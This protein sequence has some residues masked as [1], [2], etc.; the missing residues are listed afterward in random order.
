[1]P[2]TSNKFYAMRV[3]LAGRDFCL[4]PPRCLLRRGFRLDRRLPIPGELKTP[5]LNLTGHETSNDT[6]IPWGKLGRG[7]GQGS[8]ASPR[9]T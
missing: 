6:V 9:G 4:F 1:L 3:E 7:R 2:G 5:D 8:T